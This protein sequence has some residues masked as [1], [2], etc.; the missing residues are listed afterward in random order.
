M[1]PMR[2]RHPLLADRAVATADVAQ[3]GIIERP[4]KPSVLLRRSVRVAVDASGGWRLIADD[5]ESGGA[6]LIDGR[7]LRTVAE[8][9]RAL[10]GVPPF[11]V[12]AILRGA[13]WC[14]DVGEAPVLRRYEIALEPDGHWTFSVDE[15]YGGAPGVTLHGDPDVGAGGF[16][17]R[18]MSVGVRWASRA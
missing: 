12:D 5:P 3:R 11:R 9:F 15:G 8:L 2:V 13:Y 1:G 18:L 16:L 6:L 4:G 10:Y 17:A 7:S 14:V